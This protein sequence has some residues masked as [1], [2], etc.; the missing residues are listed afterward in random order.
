MKSRLRV[1][2]AALAAVVAITSSTLALAQTQPCN[3][4]D[5]TLGD[6]PTVPNTGTGEACSIALPSKGDSGSAKGLAL[7]LAAAGIGTVIARRKR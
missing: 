6:C 1:S 3:E 7:T 4:N 5:T 2:F